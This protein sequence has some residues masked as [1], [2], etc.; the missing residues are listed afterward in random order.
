MLASTILVTRLWINYKSQLDWKQT[1]T[2][3]RLKRIGY[4]GHGLLITLYQFSLQKALNKLQVLINYVSPQIF[5]CIGH[6]DNYDEAIATF[7]ALYIK[8]ANQTFARHLLATRRQKSGETMDEFLQALKTLAK[9][10]KYRVVTATK[11]R[12]EAIRDAFITGLLSGSNRQ[13]LLENSLLTLKTTFDQAR[14]LDAAQKSS[15]SYLLSH[16]HPIPPAAAATSS[17][18]V[19]PDTDD[20][21]NDTIAALPGA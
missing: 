17:L 3:V 11:Y 20:N 8:P 18:P 14:S 21:S 4:I 16:H 1:Q 7:K 5:E 12:D 15:E 2:L 13:R 10:C 6:C 19:A 9:D